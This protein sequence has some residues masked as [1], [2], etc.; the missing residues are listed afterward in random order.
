MKD[1]PDHT[2]SYHA[3]IIGCL[4]QSF[5]LF[6]LSLAKPNGYY[7]ASFDSV[8]VLLCLH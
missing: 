7:Q 4:L 1:D 2:F 5:F 6:M 8:I 3:M